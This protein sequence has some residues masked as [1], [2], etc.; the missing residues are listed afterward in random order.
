MES[1]DCKSWDLLQIEI[2][3]ILTQ[4]ME[5]MEKKKV[6]YANN[7]NSSWERYDQG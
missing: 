7:G 1:V 3:M 5:I 6:T 2:V 4:W